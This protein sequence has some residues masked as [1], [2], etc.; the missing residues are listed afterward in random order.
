MSFRSKIKSVK[1]KND[2]VV[3]VI[4]KKIFVYK[5]SNL[6]LLDQIE[7]FPNPRGSRSSILGICAINTEGEGTIL[8]T[9]GEQVGKVQVRNY[10]GKKE[11]KI[12]AHQSPI[13]YLVLNT[14]GTKLATASEKGT[15]IRIYDTLTG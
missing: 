15:V 8:A 1:L 6:Q 4:E 10:D 7:T 13:S 3:V 2:R 14:Q 11:Y 12:D 9:L 5:F